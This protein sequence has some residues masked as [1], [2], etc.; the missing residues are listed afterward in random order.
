MKSSIAVGI[1]RTYEA[2]KNKDL[3]DVTIGEIHVQV[4]LPPYLDALLHDP[5]D[6]DYP[7]EDDDDESNW[8]A[9]SLGWRL[10]PFTPW[11]SL[12]LMKDGSELE[13]I[14]DLGQSGTFEGEIKSEE[15]LEFL[16]HARPDLT[17]VLLCLYSSRTITQRP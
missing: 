3:V 4:Q 11:K 17:Y 9:E 13:I 5:E 14:E 1:K 8:G 10:P 6:V 2:I 16:D 7:S 12:L 15:M